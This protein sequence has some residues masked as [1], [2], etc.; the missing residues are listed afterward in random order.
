MENENKILNVRWFDEGIFYRLDSYENML[1]GSMKLQAVGGSIYRHDDSILDLHLGYCQA[2]RELGCLNAAE[3]KDR[4]VSF[5]QRV[6]TELSYIERLR[7]QMEDEEDE[8]D[9]AEE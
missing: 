6:K 5:R 9:E 7:K 4:L 8:F 1:I 2:L 3:Y